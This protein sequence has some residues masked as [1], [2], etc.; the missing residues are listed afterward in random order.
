MFGHGQDCS[1]ILELLCKVDK[2]NSDLLNLSVRSAQDETLQT[3]TCDYKLFKYTGQMRY[4]ERSN[5]WLRCGYGRMI[6]PNGSTLDGYW[7]NDQP[8]NF[9]V[10]R[11]MKD[12]KYEENKLASQSAF[13]SNI[14][15]MSE[16]ERFKRL[17]K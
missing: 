5:S 17:L 4:E 9:G 6:W 13:L 11:H 10:F 1:A 7:M 3:K 12:Q 8:I 14:F 15:G 2:S 16:A